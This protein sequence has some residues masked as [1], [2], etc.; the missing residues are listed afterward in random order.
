MDMTTIVGLVTGVGLILLALFMGGSARAF[1]SFNSVLIT[2]GGTL[3][4]TLVSFPVSQIVD[5]GRILRKAFRGGPGDALDV[6]TGLVKF[7]ERAR[8][9]GLLA[10]EDDADQVSDPFLKKGLQLV[11]DGSDPELVRDILQTELAFLEER[12]KTGA[13]LFD[14]LGALAPAF[15]MIGT[16]IGL[17]QMLR[18]LD[19]PSN[20]GSGM[21]VALVT[22][23]YGA[24]AANL[25][26]IPIANKLKNRSQGEILTRQVM[27]E[28]ILS[29]QAGDNPRVVEE[30]LR[31]FLA[32][33]FR[34]AVRKADADA[35]AASVATG[36]A[37][38]TTEGGQRP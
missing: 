37:G 5:T 14:T 12:H 9:E 6:I 24:L 34:E 29:I 16:I 18:N 2:F 25:V 32:P 21:A 8:R 13:A 19:D 22:T 38:T 15:G 4:A 28:G 31:V 35:G 27:L 1:W 26:F 11:V 33:R 20:I 10:L 17:I 30:K 36:A 7:A 3:A 23:F